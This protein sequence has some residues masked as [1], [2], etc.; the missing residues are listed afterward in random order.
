MKSALV[1]NGIGLGIIMM[2][3]VIWAAAGGGSVVAGDAGAIEEALTQDPPV[4][5]TPSDSPAP[6]ATA[7]AED[8]PAPPEEPA[9]PPSIP[10]FTIGQA[11]DGHDRVP[12]GLRIPAL[13][14]E[15][16]VNP[17][18]V[19]SNG[20]MEVPANVTD[21]AWYKYGSAPGEPGSAVLAAHVDLAGQGPGVFFELRDLEPG[22]VIFVDFDDGSSEAWV[23][24]ARTIY[25][26]EE[27]PTDAI[28][29]REG[30]PVLTLITCGG[31][32]NEQ[33]RRYDSNVVVYAV[34][35]ETPIAERI[36]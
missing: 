24:E 27:L 34:P 30:P 6:P 31:G 1:L 11:P 4:Q 3:L 32:F 26:K 5:E 17:A 18:G 22:S 16:A 28:F 14:Q 2:T 9:N 15:A 21:V 29:S 36:A 35:A 19:A 8:E 12:I 10:P 13:D 20:D 23:A 33:A 25:D 7:P